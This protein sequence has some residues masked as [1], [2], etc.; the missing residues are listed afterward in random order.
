MEN[1][2]RIG[3]VGEAK[4]LAE[5][6]ARQVPV[7]LPFGE[8]ERCDLVAEFGGKLNKIQVK[9]SEK[10]KDGTITW[11]IKSVT[12][13]K[14]NYS[15]H[16]YTKQEIDYFVLYNVETNLLLLVPLDKI[17]A[18]TSISFTYPFVE[19]K[20]T[21]QN[22]WEDFTFDKVLSQKESQLEV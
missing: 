5:F 16:K 3:N 19:C 1:T 22:N 14:G 20:T 2:K 12:G 10:V 8:N 11:N 15:T 4:A 21:K 6:V 17:T 9:T 13:T 18:R 7:Y